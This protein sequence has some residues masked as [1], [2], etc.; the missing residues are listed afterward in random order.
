MK[1]RRWSIIGI[2]CIV[3]LAALMSI[4][5]WAQPAGL[6]LDGV[7]IVVDPGHGG[8]DEGAQKEKVKEAQI[9]LSISQKLKSELEKL[10]ANVT[11]TRDGAY[12]LASEGAQNRKREDMKKRAAMINEDRID[13]FISV[14]LNAYP[15]VSIHGAQVFYRK[16]DEASKAF[17]DIIQKRMNTFT[18]VEKKSKT[19]DYYILNETTPPGVL[20]ECGFL[21]NENDRLN[22]TKDAYQ[23]ELAK[24]LSESVAEYLNVLSL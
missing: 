17:A 21:S 8:K 22:L 24:V 1:Y 23:Q 15:N 5:A 18:Q 16:K 4:H 12:D 11:L 13:L 10:G 7:S 2:I 9:N 6:P 14:H 3:L 19:G 20:V